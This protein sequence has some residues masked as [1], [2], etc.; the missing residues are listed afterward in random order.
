MT[1]D[2]QIDASDNPR[3]LSRLTREFRAFL[4]IFLYLVVAFGWFV[5]AEAVVEQQNG[6]SVVVTGFAVF[7]AFVLA[8]VIMIGEHF[9]FGRFRRRR[10]PLAFAI[11]LEALLFTV[12]LMVFHF[13]E[14]GAS[15]FVRHGSVWAEF[16]GF[17]RGGLLKFACVMIMLFIALLPF[18][19]YRNLARELGDRRMRDLLFAPP[20]AQEK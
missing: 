11:L 8:K 20:G 13:L 12:L 7:N 9:R 1:T 18:F 6:N 4:F 5:L 16:E 14:K 2:D 17:A 10:H 19:A 3:L 15:G